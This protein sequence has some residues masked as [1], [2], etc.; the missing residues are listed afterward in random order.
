MPTY[1]YRCREC[2]THFEAYHAVMAF[3]PDCPSCG[4]KAQRVLL[5]APAVH[6]S[7]VSGRETAMR[8]LPQCGKGCRCCP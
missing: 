2:S 7:M 6:G 1:D 8:A 4:G 3:A 5:S